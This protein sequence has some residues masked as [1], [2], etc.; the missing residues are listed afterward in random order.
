MRVHR[1]LNV[2]GRRRHSGKDGR[3]VDSCHSHICRFTRTSNY[4][5]AVK[6]SCRHC[7][8]A[9]RCRCVFIGSLPG[10]YAVA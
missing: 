2:T 5:F 3:D 7:L 6:Y 10:F 8:D 4:S 1:N 9:I